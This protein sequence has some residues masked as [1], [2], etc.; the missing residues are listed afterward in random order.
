MARPEETKVQ[1]SEPYIRST[2]GAR[3]IP[4]SPG[5]FVNEAVWKLLGALR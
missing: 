5:S 4:I 1:D 3:M 2:D